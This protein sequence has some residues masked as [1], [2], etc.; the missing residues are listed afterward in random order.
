MVWVAGVA[1]RVALEPLSERP[2]QLIMLPLER[3]RRETVKGCAGLPD[4][5]VACVAV[6]R[7]IRP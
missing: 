1:Q 5:F 3:Q 7:V 2:L 6:L 4:E